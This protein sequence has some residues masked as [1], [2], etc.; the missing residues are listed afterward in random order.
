MKHLK[1]YNESYVISSENEL[2]N[3][4]K[5]ILLDLSDIGYEYNLSFVN[6]KKRITLIDV[7]IIN[8]KPKIF[9]EIALNN[10]I[11]EVIDRLS[12]YLD[13]EGFVMYGSP[14]S[15]H[16]NRWVSPTVEIEYSRK[17]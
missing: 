14:V 7:V 15:K 16:G 11:K 13:S 10:E 5:D 9:G 6:H 3:S 8:N 12:S 2:E 1:T 17:Y 4:I